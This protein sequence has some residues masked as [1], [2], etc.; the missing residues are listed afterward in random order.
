MNKSP[1]KKAAPRDSQANNF[2]I[3]TSYAA[4]VKAGTL[5][6]YPG[7]AKYAKGLRQMNRR[8]GKRSGGKRG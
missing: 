8:A 3:D 1:K 4:Q 7:D 5:K 6:P 2:G